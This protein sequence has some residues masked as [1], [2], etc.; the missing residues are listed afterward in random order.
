MT[1]K[2]TL[3]ILQEMQKWRRGEKPYD[4]D[5]PREIPYSPKEFG[6]AIDCC[7]GMLKI[8][9]NTAEPKEY[10]TLQY[11]TEWTDCDNVVIS[12]YEKGDDFQ[13]GIIEVRLF[14]GRRKGEAYIWNLSVDEGHRGKGYGRALLSEALDTAMCADCTT[15]V[16]E[17]DKRDTPFWVY[18]WYK[19]NGFD[20]KE[21]GKGYALMIKK[22][23]ANDNQD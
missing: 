11:C 16:L 9:L 2:E 10:Y 5:V 22:L 8:K 15:A 3:S 4:G 23:Q 21:L 14:H 6:Q 7:I 1:S 13:I 19:R 18:D 12:L 20:E 17:W